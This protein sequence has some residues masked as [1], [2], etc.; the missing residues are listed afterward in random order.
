ML[1]QVGQIHGTGDGKKQLWTYRKANHLMS[2]ASR[3]FAGIYLGSTCVP[4]FRYQPN[5]DHYGIIPQR[6]AGPG[7]SDFGCS[8]LAAFNYTSAFF[9]NLQGPGNNGPGMAFE[10]YPDHRRA[11]PPCL[12]PC[13]LCL[14]GKYW[15]PRGQANCVGTNAGLPHNSIAFA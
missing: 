3:S 13:Q 8:N 15:P 12:I 1:K 11:E 4:V 5:L 9:P 2:V 10:D 6:Q 7:R 14:P